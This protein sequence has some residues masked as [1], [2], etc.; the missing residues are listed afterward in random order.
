MSDPARIELR[1]AA[2]DRSCKVSAVLLR[3][4][5]ARWLLVLA[6]GA[7]AGM[8]HPLIIAVSAELSGQSVAN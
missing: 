5:G 6:H 7:G 1:F 3:S 2:T 4:L 8:H